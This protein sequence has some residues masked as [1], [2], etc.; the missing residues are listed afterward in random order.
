MTGPT[1]TQEFLDDGLSE[2]IGGLSSNQLATRS[3]PRLI[4]F[5]ARARRLFE[6]R[7]SDVQSQRDSLVLLLRK[8]DD[9]DL[10]TE[11]LRVATASSNQH[12][13][14][15][16]IDVLS[17]IGESCLAFAKAYT[18]NEICGRGFNGDR[19]WKPNSDF[20]YI[21]LRAA[22]RCSAPLQDRE[23]FVNRFVGSINEE[24]L[25][26]VA[27]GVVEALADLAEQGSV[28][29]RSA[30]R[31]IAAESSSAVVCEMAETALED[32]D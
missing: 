8:D 21:L 13:L 4:S 9:F 31:Q 10:L 18:L 30:L 25:A 14:D 24:A 32:L 16:G 19:P 20:W 7:I 17:Q 22:A 26:P 1:I 12:R 23:S 3:S 11:L 2:R 27:E 15:I 29:A 6:A 5:R 28:R